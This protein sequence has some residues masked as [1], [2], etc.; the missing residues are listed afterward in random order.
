MGWSGNPLNWVAREVFSEEAENLGRDL[1]GEKEPCD[2]GRG[3]AFQAQSPGCAQQNL[4]G[5]GAFSNC[6]FPSLPLLP[7]SVPGG[8]CLKSLEKQ[9]RPYLRAG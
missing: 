7:L 1:T 5:R 4:Q 2:G 8:H 9:C 6:M 3:T